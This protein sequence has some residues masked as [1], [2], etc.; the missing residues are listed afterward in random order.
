ML[1]NADLNNVF[2]GGVPKGFEHRLSRRYEV[3]ERE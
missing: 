2:V 3:V 1:S